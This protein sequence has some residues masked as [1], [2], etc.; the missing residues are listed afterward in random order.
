MEQPTSFTSAGLRFDA[1]LHRPDNARGDVPAFIALNGFGGKKEGNQK[2]GR[3][4][5]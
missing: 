2:I 4:H 1:V 3:A 5:V